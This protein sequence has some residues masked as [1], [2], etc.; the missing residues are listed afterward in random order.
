MGSVA[1]AFGSRLLHAW[2]RLQVSYYGGKYSIERALAL[3]TYTKNTSLLRVCAVCISTPLRMIAIVILQELV[4][5]QDPNDGWKANY[6]FWIR[7]TLLIFVGIPPLTVQATYFING[8]RISACRQVLLSLCVSIGV[9]SCALA[10]AARLIFPIPFYLLS[11]SPVLYV[12]LAISFRV[13][14]GK[15]TLQYM[16]QRRDKLHRFVNYISAKFIPVFLY[17]AYEALFRIADG[18]QYQFFVILLLPLI[19]LTLKNIMLRCTAHMEDMTPEAVIFTVDFFNALYMAT[20]MQSSSSAASVTV[21]TLTDM[22]QT[23]IMI[24][25][26]HHRTSTILSRLTKSVNTFDKN[27]GLLLIL[28]LLCRDP[29]TFRKQ[30]SIGI[31]IRSCLPHDL[32]ETDE[33]IL[34]QF[35]PLASAAVLPAL[36][37]ALK[38]R[39]CIAWSARKSDQQKLQDASF[40]SAC[41]RSG[42][43]IFSDPGKV[44]ILD[45][46]DAVFSFG[47]LR[48][49]LNKSLTTS[50]TTVTH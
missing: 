39:N 46:I 35:D 32:S 41:V 28:G 13:V 15:Q 27:E 47:T 25:G 50:Q 40:A 11:L 22:F 43:P 33:H 26:L 45:S 2:K 30:R 4:P 23:I 48:Y 38:Q 20:C 21:I 16:L 19:K 17:P 12:V 24:Y 37:K 8:V 6:G 34:K 14:V 49:V 7:V 9:I 36:T 44:D 18:S 31:R 3:E 42:N 1:V 29:D 5:L 10:I